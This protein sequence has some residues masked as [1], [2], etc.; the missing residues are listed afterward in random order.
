MLNLLE[1]GLVNQWIREIFPPLQCEHGTHLSAQQITLSGISSPLAILA[2]G[3]IL[4]SAALVF[5]KA[6]KMLRDVKFQTGLI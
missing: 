3:L 5:E 4:A 1:T 6:I 2:A